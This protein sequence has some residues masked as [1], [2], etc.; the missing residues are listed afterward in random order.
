[1]AKLRVVVTGIG[2][3]S[4][5]GHTIEDTWNNVIAGRPNV[6]PITRFD[7]SD[8]R[9]Q[10]ASQIT[11]LDLTDRLDV[12][13]VRR[14]DDYVCTALYAAVQ[15]VEDCG[16]DF[17]QIDPTRG[18]VIIGS[19]IGGISAVL[20]NYDV[21]QQEGVRRVSPFAIPSMLIDSAPGQI[22]IEYGLRGP[23]LG[24]VGACASGNYGVGEAYY[25]IVRGDA[26]VMV[27]GGVECGVNR[28]TMA[29]FERA[30]A[31]S[32]RNGDPNKA[33][34]PFDAERDGFVIGEGAAILILER[35]E[36][37]LARDAKIY[38]EVMGY[39]A[40]AD[41]YHLTAPHED[42]LGAIEAMEVALRG[43]DLSPA[44][45]DYINAHGTSTPLNDAAETTAIK[46]VFGETAYSIPVSS[47]K[48]VTGHL[49]GAAGAFEAVFCLLAMRDSIVPPT[50]NLDVP[51]PACDLD[52]VP[53]QARPHQ[54]RFAA[55]NSFGF[56]GHNSCLVLGDYRNG[57]Q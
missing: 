33:S 48:S 13:V 39:S 11:D 52:Y 55:S 7:V 34:R 45:I 19:A 53:H 32:A 21:L 36:H 28:Y 26:D 54:V 24:V 51:D 17:S 1:M 37:A 40:T 50:I 3:V 35:L 30:R 9:T 44:D 27:T 4:P 10:F 16:I 12:R 14:L 22:A 47:T 38:G 2:A 8:L 42:G 20:K 25:A 43:A 23:N 29:G 56:G 5:V 6:T 57:S 41:A 31:M 46:K 15:A 18:G 49:L